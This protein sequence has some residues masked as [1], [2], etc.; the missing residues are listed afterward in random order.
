MPGRGQA[1]LNWAALGNGYLAFRNMMQAAGGL[2]MTY[3]AYRGTPAALLDLAAGHL[4]VVV[5]PCPGAA[6]AAE[7]R[8]RALAVTNPVRSPLF[9][10]V[11]TAAESG[12]PALEME[13]AHGLFGWRGMPEPLRD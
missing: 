4:Q 11:P 5:R 6:A 3:I 12:F 2:D 9:P 7:G 1:R 8:I 13:G 10:E